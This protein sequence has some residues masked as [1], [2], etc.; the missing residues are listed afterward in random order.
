VSLRPLLSFLPLFTNVLEDA[1]SDLHIDHP[2]LPRQHRGEELPTASPCGLLPG[3]LFPDIYPGS[4][5]LELAQSL[6]FMCFLLGMIGSQVYPYRSVST[7]NQ[8]RQTKW[9]V[10]GTTL[11][12]SVLLAVVA[13]L[14]LFAPG[15]ARTSPFVLLVI[16]NVLPLIM[17]L[18]PLSVG[19]A[20]LRSG[21]FDIDVVI[22][23]ALV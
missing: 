3:D 20:M 1:F 18:I 5:S 7:P 14:F 13:P 19:V 22:N 11:A 12:L 8:R 17:V 4:P 23:R 21:L 10:V 2:A 15:V 6:T 16:G 9:V